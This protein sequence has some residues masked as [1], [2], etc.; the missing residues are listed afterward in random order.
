V[1][2]KQVLRG[3]AKTVRLE[4]CW[5]KRH[6]GYV[7]QKD[8]YKVTITKPNGEKYFAAVQKNG[9]VAC[10][11]MGYLFYRKCKHAKFISEVIN[12]KGGK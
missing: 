2:K 9:S 7:Y 1:I 6:D 12:K 3:L 8:R 5:V 4:A 11:C 10:N